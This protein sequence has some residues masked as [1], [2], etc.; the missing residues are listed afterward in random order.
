MSSLSPQMGLH[1]TYE[2]DIETDN[3]FYLYPDPI[4]ID[5]ILSPG[6]W[7]NAINVKKWYMDV[8]T[9]NYDGYNYMYLTEDRD[10]LY[11]AI[12]LV[13]DQTNDETGEWLGIWL[14]TNGTFIN[15][16]NYT[17][18]NQRW[19]DSLNKGM[20]S[21]IIDVDNNQTMPYFAVDGSTDIEYY[22]F[23]DLNT[24]NVIEGTLDG[25]FDALITPNDN[26]WL[27]MTAAWNET[28]YVYRLDIEI[29][30]SEYYT[31]FPELCTDETLGVGI[32]SYLFNNVTI[33]N[34][35]YSI[36]NS[37]GHLL[38]D[39]PK[40]TYSISAGT[41]K[42]WNPAVFADP[43]N[44][45]Q[46]NKIFLSYVGVNDAPFKTSFDYMELELLHPQ[47]TDI[48][49]G[50]F[51]S[52]YYPYTS[53]NNYEIDWTFG[54]SENNA[55]DHRIFEL[56]IP[57]SELEGYTD[58]TNL[59]IILGGYGTLSFPGTNYWVLSEVDGTI[60]IFLTPYY[61][62]YTMPMKGWTPLNDPV[63]NALDPSTSGNITLDWNDDA[64]VR[65]W[66][67]IR[68]TS[69]I[70]KNSIGLVDIL[71]SGLTT[72]QYTDTGLTNGTYYYGIVAVDEIAYLYLSNIESVV[73][74]IP[75][76]TPDP[77]LTP[78]ST[79]TPT[80]TTKP[81]P[82]PTSSTEE[83]LFP[84]IAIFLGVVTIFSTLI[85]KKNRK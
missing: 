81:T 27:I 63:L 4:I 20:E 29:P 70:N 58:D 75:E 49:G 78:T 66:T 72:S 46:D 79:P 26:E 41:S 85:Y 15:D 18:N 6:E 16:P 55:T 54:P 61:I 14:N 52:P 43:G 24:F 68:H 39:N 34:H 3:I 42:T 50:T 12:D 2:D 53:I 48:L 17:D 44:F 36:R 35:Y 37:T 51:E 76:P 71:A 13:S 11:F 40:Q 65:N 59:G 56:K 74:G 5:G 9:E 22:N 80:P 23:K 60:W 1:N 30:Y 84:E 19:H 10:N 77:T 38:I 73:V 25:S 64:G 28:D 57:K 83:S 7:D 31:M 21:L 32:T 67:V 47:V 82:T 45:T 69:E 62:N 33:D 8:D